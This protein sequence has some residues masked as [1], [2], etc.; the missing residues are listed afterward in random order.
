MFEVGSKFRIAMRG[1]CANCTVTDI[2]ETRDFTGKL[3]KLYT[4]D[5]VDYDVETTYTY[6]QLAMEATMN[7]QFVKVGK[8]EVDTGHFVIVDVDGVEDVPTAIDL[9][10]DQVYQMNFTTGVVVGSYN[11]NFAVYAA[12]VNNVYT[13]GYFI[14]MD[15]SVPQE[16]SLS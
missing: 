6:D 9:G 4:V 14:S 2:Q 5:F 7:V 12:I 3:I 11:G 1:E 16:I 10:V 13:A 8:V 15:G